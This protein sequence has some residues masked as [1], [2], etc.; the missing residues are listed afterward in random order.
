ML[1]CRYELQLLTQVVNPRSI[2][3][4]ISDIAGL[5]GVIQS[6]VDDSLFMASVP[7]AGSD[8]MLASSKGLLLYGPPGTGKTMVAKVC[9]C[10]FSSVVLS[11][12]LCSVV[13]P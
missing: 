3:V 10:C 2:D 8:S 5:D 13:M 11:S 9:C 1:F 7:G 6:I 12:A 4:D